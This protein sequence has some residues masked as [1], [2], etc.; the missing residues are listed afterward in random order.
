MAM[1]RGNL[2]VVALA[3]GGAL[4][5]FGLSMWL[6][7][8]RMPQTAA[9]AGTARPALELPDIDGTRTSIARWDGRLVL[10]NFWASWCGPCVE[11]MPLLDRMQQRHAAAGLQIVGIATDGVQPTRDFLGRHP[12]A[13]PIL[14]DD[15]DLRTNTGDSAAIYGNTRNVL[16][17]SVLIGRDGRILAQHYGNF[18]ETSLDAWL[19][20]H[21]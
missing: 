7:P 21:L 3:L 16:P 20:P 19:R 13:Y 4:G 10:V 14:I 15:P 8:G 5:G 1:D 11:E 17:Y 6:H 2:L 12:V 18:S 9:L